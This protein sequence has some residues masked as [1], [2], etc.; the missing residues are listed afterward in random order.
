MQ[1]N[2]NIMPFESIDESAC[3]RVRACVL[4]SVNY[5]CTD[6]LQL[7]LTNFSIANVVGRLKF[8]M[9]LVLFDHFHRGY[10]WR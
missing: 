8:A 5:S 10:P 3:S 6:Q 9:L 7:H 1:V 4:S 2:I